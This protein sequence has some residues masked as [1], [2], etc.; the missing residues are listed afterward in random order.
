LEGS[1]PT[2]QT[3]WRI[4]TSFNLLD[5]RSLLSF[6]TGSS[7]IPCT[8]ALVLK[9]VNAGEGGFRFITSRTCFNQLNL[10]NYGK[11]AGAEKRMEEMLRAAWE[12][13]VGF[14]LK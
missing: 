6:I 1:D 13:S 12:G 5:Q 11:G 4:F 2:V 10:H 3:F 8:G 7:L 9:I 14:D